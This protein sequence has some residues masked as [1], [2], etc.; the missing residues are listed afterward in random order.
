MKFIYGTIMA[1]AFFSLMMI[2]QAAD[3]VSFMVKDFKRALDSGADAAARCIA[4]DTSYHLDKNGTGYGVG[5]DNSNNID[6]NKDDAITWFYRVYFKNLGYSKDTEKQEY[7]KDYIP[8]KALVCFDRIY[9][10][11]SNDDWVT[12]QYYDITCNGVLYRFTLSD[13]VM[14]VSTGEWKRDTDFGISESTRKQLV[15]SFIQSEIEEVVNNRAFQDSGLK[16]DIDFALSDTDLKQNA[17]SGVNFI[18]ISEGMPLPSLNPW[19]IKKFYAYGLGGTEL[20]RQ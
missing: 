11:D 14:K 1:F 19:N 18:V 16:Y 7:L 4:Y 13:Q 10:A 6:I 3:N 8:V 5:S 17:M 12:D 2:N 15:R 20:T 9:I